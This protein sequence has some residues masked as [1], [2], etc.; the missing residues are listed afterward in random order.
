MYSVY[1]KN[2]PV[3]PVNYYLRVRRQTK[4]NILL[5]NTKYQN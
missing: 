1:K 2:P 4:V 5:T 3:M